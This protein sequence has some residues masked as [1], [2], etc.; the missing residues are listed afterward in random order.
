ML[1]KN[2][3]KE[4][5][6]EEVPDEAVKAFRKIIQKKKN[7]IEEKETEELEERTSVFS[8]AATACLVFAVAVA[9]TKFYQHYQ[10]I[11]VLDSRTEAVSAV[12]EAEQ[13]GM[14][15]DE[16]TDKKE[17]IKK[18]EKAA[19]QEENKTKEKIQENREKT[20]GYQDDKSQK[21]S[22]GTAAE[23]KEEN[24]ESDSLKKENEDE[25]IRETGKQNE[26]N[27]EESGAESEKQEKNPESIYKQ[28]S[29]IRK[30]EK[31]VREQQKGMES[32]SEET[33]GNSG[34]YIIRPGDTLYQISI[35]NYGNMDAVEEICRLNGI[36]ADEIIYPGQI[37]VLP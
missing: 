22:S 3:G 26:K 23:E 6:Q 15:D 25:G 1:E 11:Q 24:L 10:E 19:G 5:R 9:G 34:T 37:I 13:Q 31:R 12:M 7:N 18:E 33:S 32:K 14:E 8:Y 27:G 30:A 29:D 2:A 20:N 4:Q 28:E 17:T 36:T 16:T 35:Q 21:H